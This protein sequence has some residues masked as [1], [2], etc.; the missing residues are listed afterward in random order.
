MRRIKFD[1]ETVNSI[2]K[3]INEGHTISQTCNRFTLKRDTLKRV[4]RE[5]NIKAFYSKAD[6]IVRDIPTET[7]S[8]VCNLFEHTET[9][10]QDICKEANL[11]YWEMQEILNDHYSKEFQQKRKSHLYSLSKQVDKNPMLGKTKE[12]HHNYKGEV[13]DGKGYLQCLKPDWYTGRKGSKH[14]FVHT[15]VMCEYLGL[16]ELPKGWVVHHINGNKRDNDIN[17]LALLTNSAHTKLHSIQTKLCKV[18]RLSNNGVG[19]NS[20]EMPDKD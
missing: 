12:L 5:N 3:Y 14:V 4:M 19:N 7:I 10:L 16:T 18:Q 11:E 8:L 6:T 1:E 2:R 15:V 20:T 13:G 9:R 17:N